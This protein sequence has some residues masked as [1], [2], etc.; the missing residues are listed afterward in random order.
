VA[1]GFSAMD[2]IVH[3]SVRPTSLFFRNGYCSE[4]CNTSTV[5]LGFFPQWI[6]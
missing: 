3:N 4:Q 2:L 1:L 6:W 5:A